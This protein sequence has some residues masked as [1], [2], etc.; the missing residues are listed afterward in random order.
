M[1]LV[2]HQQA[3][4]KVVYVCSK[5]KSKHLRTGILTLHLGRDRG[6]VQGGGRVRP[7]VNEFSLR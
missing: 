2:I 7:Q 6:K 4:S 1:G 5:R 3:L